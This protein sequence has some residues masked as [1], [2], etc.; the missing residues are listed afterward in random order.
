[1]ERVPLAVAP[2]VVSVA[3]I[4][5][6]PLRVE[7]GKNMSQLYEPFAA[8]TVKSA[9]P[10]TEIFRVLPLVNPTIAT[11]VRPPAVRE[12]GDATTPGVFAAG[13]S[14]AAASPEDHVM[15]PPSKFC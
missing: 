9:W 4:V 10:V 1:M 5:R 11:R 8:T 2:L 15:L 3:S 12:L 13:C 6:D 7:I 14:F